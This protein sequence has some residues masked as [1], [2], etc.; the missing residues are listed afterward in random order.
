M[1]YFGVIDIIFLHH[2]TSEV[3]GQCWYSVCMVSCALLQMEVI[4]EL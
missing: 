1:L 4:L 2:Q 3:K